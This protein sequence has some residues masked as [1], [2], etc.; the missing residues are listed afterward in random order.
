MFFYTSIFELIKQ[1]FNCSFLN[2]LYL[3]S[4]LKII[5]LKIFIRI[6]PT[7]F[8]SISEMI[9]ESVQREARQRDL[10]GRCLLYF[11]RVQAGTH[12][13]PG[14]HATLAWC[15]AS[16]SLWVQMKVLSLHFILVNW[17]SYSFFKYM[18]QWKSH[19]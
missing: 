11:R 1:T 19:A 2:L 7:E 13:T 3:L 18:P 10:L 4:V 16:T 12:I 5:V 8:N 17:G 15:S 14:A 6:S 9:D